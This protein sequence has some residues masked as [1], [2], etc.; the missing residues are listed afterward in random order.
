MPLCYQVDVHQPASH[1]S[2]ALKGNVNKTDL[3]CYSEQKLIDYFKMI[4]MFRH[5]LS[6]EFQRSG[7][8]KLSDILVEN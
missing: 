6:V 5:Q 7:G 1:L 8:T 2:L 3:H 4:I